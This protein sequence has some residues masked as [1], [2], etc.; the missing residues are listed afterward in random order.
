[1]ENRLH[2]DNCEILLTKNMNLNKFSCASKSIFYLCDEC[3][4]D[5]EVARAYHLIDDKRLD[6]PCINYYERD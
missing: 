6:E 5:N 3:L 1:M 4:E 2:C